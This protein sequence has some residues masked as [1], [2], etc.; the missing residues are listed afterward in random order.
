MKGK[1]LLGFIITVVITLSAM[2]A[3]TVWA[4]ETAAAVSEDD[5]YPLSEYKD[6]L[7]TDPVIGFTAWK[8]D[9]NYIG[10]AGLLKTGDYTPNPK[11]VTTPNGEY[12]YRHAAEDDDFRYLMCP[13]T[14]VEQVVIARLAGAPLAGYDQ[15][16]INGEEVAALERV[17]REFLNSFDWRNASDEEKAVRIVKRI[18][19][20]EYDHSDDSDANKSDFTYGCLINGTAKCGGYVNA[21]CYLGFCVNLP[22][23]GH[24]VGNHMYTL[25]R[26]NGVW[27]SND[28][29]TKDTTFKIYDPADG[30]YMAGNMKCFQ[31]VG[32]F[33][34]RMGYQTPETLDGIIHNMTL[35]DGTRIYKSHAWYGGRDADVMQFQ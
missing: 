12:M 25:F 33:C 17:T 10:N 19:Q 3:Q 24:G 15:E 30:Y 34:D 35:S 14:G 28:S 29:T 1:K 6:W 2:P 5:R 11:Y 27:L 20:A 31:Q 8:W 26:V 9:D 13:G 7:V 22:V 18:N 16:F 23:S 32:E 21:A 4:E